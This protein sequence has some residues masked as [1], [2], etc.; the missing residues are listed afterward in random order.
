MATAYVEWGS[1]GDC[2]WGVTVLDRRNYSCGLWDG[3]HD[4]NTSRSVCL[5]CDTGMVMCA[6]CGVLVCDC[7]NARIG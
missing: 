3:V 5:K 6:E 7:L 2:E 4:F 1:G